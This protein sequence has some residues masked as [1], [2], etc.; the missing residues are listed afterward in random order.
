MPNR[1]RLGGMTGMGMGGGGQKSRRQVSLVEGKRRPRDFMPGPDLPKGRVPM[2]RISVLEPLQTVPAERVADL[3]APGRRYVQPDGLPLMRLVVD[4]ELAEFTRREASARRAGS[5]GSCAASSAGAARPRSSSSPARRNPKPPGPWTGPEPAGTSEP[6]DLSLPIRGFRSL[7]T[8]DRSDPAT[9]QRAEAT[10]PFGG[11]RKSTPSAVLHLRLEMELRDHRGTR[12]S[13]PK[14]V[15]C[16]D[17]TVS[18]ARKRLVRS[19]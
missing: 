2:S 4:D 12:T 5:T 7:G 3:E 13:R 15:G 19:A 10:P 18:A 11:A 8:S 14:R 17:K 1:G 16:S 6:S 9:T